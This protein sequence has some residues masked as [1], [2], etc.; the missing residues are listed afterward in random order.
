MVLHAKRESR[1][2]ENWVLRR[3]LDLRARRWRE[4]GED[5]MRSFVTCTL[6]Q[7]LLG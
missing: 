6:H 4:V 1:V 5:Y 3:N 2:F 7:I